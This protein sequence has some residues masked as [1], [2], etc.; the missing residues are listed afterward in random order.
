MYGI[1]AEQSPMPVSFINEGD[2]IKFGNSSLNTL[3]TPG[4]SRE[5]FL[6]II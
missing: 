5:V 3:H 6:I 4:H 2:V 1:P